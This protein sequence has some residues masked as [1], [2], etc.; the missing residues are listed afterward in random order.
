MA[1]KML[2]AAENSF[3]SK[4]LRDGKE[5]LFIKNIQNTNKTNLLKVAVPNLKFQFHCNVC[6]DDEKKYTQ[7]HPNRYTYHL[8]SPLPVRLCCQDSHPTHNHLY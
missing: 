3:L 8:K 7:D 4:I 5:K 1:G 2:I 6:S